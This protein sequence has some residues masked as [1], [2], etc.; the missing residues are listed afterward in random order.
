VNQIVQDV[1]TNQNDLAYLHQ[2]Y[3]P[4]LVQLAGNSKGVQTMRGTLLRGQAQMGELERKQ[5]SDAAAALAGATNDAEFQQK[6]KDLQ[7]A[8]TPASALSEWSGKTWS[9]DLQF[10]LMTR[11]APAAQRADMAMTYARSH[12]SSL[13]AA[14]QQGGD[15]WKQAVGR[16]PKAVQ[17][18]FSGL[19]PQPTTQDVERAVMTPAELIK[20]N[21]PPAGGESAQ[22]IADYLRR[23]PGRTVQDAV[24][25]YAIDK[26]EPQRPPQVIMM[27]PNQQGGATATVVR[28]GTT[29]APGAVTAAGYNALNLPTSSTRTMIEAAP[30]VLNLANRI[31]KEIDQQ[32][33]SLGPAASR[34][35]EFM[36]RKVGAPNPEFTKL[37]TD[38][39]LLTTLLM[40]MHVGARGGE[41]MMQH[42]Q[43]LLATGKQSP[44]N[45]KAALQEIRQ[46]TQDRI[47]EGASVGAIRSGGGAAPSPSTRPPLTEI[48]K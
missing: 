43:N 17:P 2:T 20:A 23:N 24:R 10:E 47:S 32:K 12:L 45:L 4:I 41:G 22:Y 34:W 36:T 38:T 19:P 14:A 48:F 39:D 35:N 7:T 31:D 30:G 37:V 44:E 42:F 21:A 40:R 3:D 46:Y 25:Q 18:I 11:D 9:P 26:Q 8:G 28:P 6:L 16:L 5:K 15:A 29:V 13:S 33:A 27:V 1:Q